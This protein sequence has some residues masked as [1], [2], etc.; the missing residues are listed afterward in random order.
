MQDVKSMTGMSE[1]MVQE[2][3]SR[4]NSLKKSLEALEE[5]QKTSHLQNEQLRHQKSV[6]QNLIG[7]LR[8]RQEPGDTS[9]NAS[10]RYVDSKYV[11]KYDRSYDNEALGTTS[12][13]T[14]SKYLDSRHSSKYARGQDNEDLGGSSYKAS[15][16]YLGSKYE[17]K[18]GGSYDNRYEDFDTNLKD[19]YHTKEFKEIHDGEKSA[20]D[21][22][23]DQFSFAFQEYPCRKCSRMEQKDFGRSSAYY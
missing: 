4:N 6:L 9:Y 3:H 14:S 8:E 10:S 2:L 23:G 12:Y 5:G 19:R 18:Y 21:S 15:S 16:R 17:S 1:E 22:K 7:D 13:N 20:R 11:S